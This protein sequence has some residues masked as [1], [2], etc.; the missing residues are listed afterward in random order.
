MLYYRTNMKV[1]FEADEKINSS[2]IKALLNISN[3]KN[4]LLSWKAFDRYTIVVTKGIKIIGMGWATVHREH[5]PEK[6]VVFIIYCAL[7]NCLSKNY[8]L[9]D[10][11]AWI[12]F[13]KKELWL[14]IIYF[15]GLWQ[16]VWQ[17]LLKG[18]RWLFIF[19]YCGWSEN[20]D[21]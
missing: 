18:L 14:L 17:L 20:I 9:Q 11:C 4:V 13:T 2:H 16:F 10:T 8:F 12:C 1:G 5:R 21:N 3:N 15:H 19:D 7:S 6:C